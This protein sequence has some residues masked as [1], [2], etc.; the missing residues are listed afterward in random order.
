MIRMVDG[1]T[2]F[3]LCVCVLD[4]WI[5]RLMYVGTSSGKFTQLVH[6]GPIGAIFL[7]LW[8]YVFVL[9]ELTN[10]VRYV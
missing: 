3:Y 6:Y 4:K 9:I 8:M 7:I 1:D 5:E 2:V 10:V